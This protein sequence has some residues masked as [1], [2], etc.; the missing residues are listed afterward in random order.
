MFVEARK[1]TK[2]LKT[3]ITATDVKKAAENRQ[4]SF[5]L[6]RDSIITPSAQDTAQ[7]LGI[8]IIPASNPAL[9]SSALDPAIVAK[10]VGEVMACL[11]QSEQSSP[12]R[13]EVDSCGLRLVRGDSVVLEDYDTGHPR[14]K[15][16][17]KELFNSRESGKV[18]AG[19]M[20][21]EATSYSAPIKHD[22][23]HY[24]IDGTLECSVENRT[25]TGKQGDLFFIPADTNVRFSTSGNVKILYLASIS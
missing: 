10:I 24:I 1:V 19:I 25:Y 2:G 21:F 6:Q 22:E 3:L 23:L 16:K 4:T 13:K 15:V 17:I 5:Y 9:A 14:D 8:R 20:T 11:S 18:S 12:L 7:D